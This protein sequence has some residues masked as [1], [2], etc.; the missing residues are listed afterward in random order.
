M[1]NVLVVAALVGGLI[2]FCFGQ[3]DFQPT[4]QFRASE[5][6]NELTASIDV[7]D[8]ERKEFTAA[9]D[10]PEEGSGVLVNVYGGSGAFFSHDPAIEGERFEVLNFEFRS[11]SPSGWAEYV[12]AAVDCETDKVVPMPGG[13]ALL[14]HFDDAHRD[15]QFIDGFGFGDSGILAIRQVC[16]SDDVLEWAIALESRVGFQ[17]DPHQW[18]EPDYEYSVVSVDVLQ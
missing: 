18:S 16:D 11:G 2:D 4:A 6:V 17:V 10:P 14:V 12:H 15:D 5:G 7:W 3:L 8:T 9:P 13:A 1:W